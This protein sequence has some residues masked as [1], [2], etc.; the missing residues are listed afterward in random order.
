M[1]LFNFFKPKSY[2]EK[3]MQQNAAQ[4][5]PAPASP[6]IGG[7]L[8]MTIEDAFHITG[9]GTVTTGT[10]VATVHTGQSVIVR[11]TA[12]DVTSTITGIE[13]NQ[14]SVDTAQ[15]GDAVGIF[16]ATIKRDQVQRGDTILVAS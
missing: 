1:G 10:L 8:L 12:G 6:V 7:G 5:P 16:L 14:Q 13:T 15:P 2:T 9:R 4:T 11:S 3:L